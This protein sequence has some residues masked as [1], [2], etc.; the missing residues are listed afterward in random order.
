MNVSLFHIHCT[1]SAPTVAIPATAPRWC[2][3]RPSCGATQE[4]VSL[5]AVTRAGA[6]AAIKQVF[7]PDAAKI[8]P[9]L[10]PTADV[11]S[12]L[13]ATYSAGLSGHV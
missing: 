8:G 4:A 7:R 13:K 6:I 10:V 3:V 1:I 12:T 5:G 9:P 11:F 2:L